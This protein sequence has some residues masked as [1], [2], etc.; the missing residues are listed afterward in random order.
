MYA[1]KIAQLAPTHERRHLRRNV[2]TLTYRRNRKKSRKAPVA[3][4][5][6][7][8]RHRQLFLIFLF[9]VSQFF[10]LQSSMFVV[11]DV[12]VQSGDKVDEASVL[13]AMG[14]SPGARYWEISPESLQADVQELNGVESAKVDVL[15]PGRVSV[16]VAERKPLF[17]VSSLA[18]TK[19]VYNVDREGVVISKGAAPAGSL[20]VVLDRDIKVGGRLS[21]N[22]LEV[23]EYLRGHIRPGLKARLDSV[24]FDDEGGMTLRVAYKAGKIPIRLGRPEKLSYKLFLLEEL[25]ASLKAEGA[26]VVSVD[27][28]FSTPIVRQPYQKPATPPEAVPAE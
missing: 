20:R 16:N 18:R 5:I 1:R 13:K 19:Q 22:E 3:R 21:A 4:E 26:E 12:A 23:C 17:T 25:L 9:V 27:L 2:G 14:I 10:F 24:R 28:R 11:N 8:T 15:F 6:Q 7:V